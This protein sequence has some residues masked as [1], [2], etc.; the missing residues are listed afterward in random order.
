M[1]PPPD[2]RSRGALGS[3]QRQTWRCCVITVAAPVLRRKRA[4]IICKIADTG[5]GR[6][7]DGHQDRDH[8]CRW[9]Q[10]QRPTPEGRRPR[11]CQVAYP[12]ADCSN[13]ERRLPGAPKWQY[14]LMMAR[15]TEENDKS[16]TQDEQRRLVE[17]ALVTP[18]IAEVINLYGRLSSYLR[19]VN[20]Q[21]SQ[22][23]NASGGNAT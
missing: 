15:G 18:G 20:V 16:E 10:S 9:D 19:I 13:G 14:W 3:R 2:D 5:A 1:I 12:V 22:V 7:I 23:H 21:P 17:R 11:T 8:L 4:E 6:V